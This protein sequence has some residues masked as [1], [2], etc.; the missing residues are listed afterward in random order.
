M[1]AERVQQWSAQFADDNRLPLLAELAHVLE[2]T[3]V[4]RANWMK[5]LQGLV[6]EPKL[7]GSDPVAFWKTANFFNQQ[8]RGV[9]QKEMLA[10]FDGVLAENLGLQLGSCGS[11]AGP[12]I[13]LDDVICTATHVLWDLKDWIAEAA[14]QSCDLHIIVIASHSARIFHREQEL[15]K[16]AKAAGRYLKTHWWRSLGLEVRPGADTEVLQPRVLPDGA[17]VAALVADLKSLGYPPRLRS[18]VTKPSNKVFSSETGREV[19]E[20]EFLIAGAKLKY[21]LAPHLK[22]NH[23]PLGYDV[24]R[25]MGFGTTVVTFRNCPN[26]CPLAWWCGDPWFPLFPREIN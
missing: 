23:W 14:P 5:F 2:R 10:L 17:S 19:L 7:V 22:Q 16:V 8:K 4:S 25:S 15:Q 21:D 11:D 6:Q 9:S 1:N 3:Y 20:R 24:F 18:V 13:Y 26:N 12:W